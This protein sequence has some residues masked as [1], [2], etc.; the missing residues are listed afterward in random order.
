MLDS[1]PCNVC[2]LKRLISSRPLN[3]LKL[4]RA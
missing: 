2:I 3:I 4:L 1:V